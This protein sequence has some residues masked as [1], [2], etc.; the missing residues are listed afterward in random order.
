MRTL[1]GNRPMIRAAHLHCMPETADPRRIFFYVLMNKH[2]TCIPA[3]RLMTPVSVS[4]QQETCSTMPQ[5]KQ[6]MNEN[7][8]KQSRY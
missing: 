2:G 8:L 1:Q 5:Q 7:S 6:P 4:E 3:L